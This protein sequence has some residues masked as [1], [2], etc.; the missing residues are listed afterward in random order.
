MKT[1][2][3]KRGVSLVEMMCVIVIVGIISVAAMPYYKKYQAQAK[4][5]DMKADLL[6]LQKNWLVFTSGSSYCRSID[7]TPA[8]IYNVGMGHLLYSFKYSLPPPNSVWLSL[9]VTDEYNN[10]RSDVGYAPPKEHLHNVDYD[11]VPPKDDPGYEACLKA[12][13]GGLELPLARYDDMG[14]PFWIGMSDFTTD[15][16]PVTVTVRKKNTNGTW[17]RD[18][19]GNIET[20]DVTR[21]EQVA[22]AGGCREGG[23]SRN[24]GDLNHL[25]RG[26][27]TKMDTR[28]RVGD[29]FCK[30]F[31]QKQNNH[32]RIKSDLT[33]ALEGADDDKGSLSTHFI[34][35]GSTGWAW[36]CRLRQKY[37]SMGILSPAPDGKWYSYGID[38]EGD[39]VDNYPN[40]EIF[41]RD[42]SG[43]AVG[44]AQAAMCFNLDPNP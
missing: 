18:A 35:I 8:T 22:A 42:H 15:S 7:G 28:V 6:R 10:A 11:H 3:L 34:G 39:F 19:N 32:W 17:A 5:A 38:S 25:R 37:F 31:D 13:K 21:T 36:R 9:G 14:K 2:L 30:K 29:T 24:A 20:E 43:K 1:L 44:S 23:T 26:V 41:A 4:K 33:T 16:Q 27:N 40:G 12:N